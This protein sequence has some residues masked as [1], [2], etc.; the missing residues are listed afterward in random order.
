MLRRDRSQGNLAGVRI[1]RTGVNECNGDVTPTI[2]ESVASRASLLS[3]VLSPRVQSRRAQRQ[4]SQASWRYRG[5]IR[6][7]F[8]ACTNRFVGNGFIGI[9]LNLP[10]TPVTSEAIHA[11]SRPAV[12]DLAIDLKLETQVVIFHAIPAA[13]KKQR[14]HAGSLP[15]GTSLAQS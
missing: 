2:V 9:S 15:R 1:G 5:F 3:R 10:Y 6:T 14:R 11:H 13:W 7:S 4:H 12:V 8:V